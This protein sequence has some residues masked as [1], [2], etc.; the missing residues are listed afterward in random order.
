[1]PEASSIK[2]VVVKIE[3]S[4]QRLTEQIAENRK[5]VE[6]LASNLIKMLD[7]SLEKSYA[8]VKNVERE[9]D[10]FEEQCRLVESQMVEEVERAKQLSGLKDLEDAINVITEIVEEL[11]GK[12]DLDKLLVAV[13]RFEESERSL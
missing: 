13:Q 12:I 8:V 3:K 4:I 6:G 5:V 10:T 1:M 2:D 7:A 9:V 11:S